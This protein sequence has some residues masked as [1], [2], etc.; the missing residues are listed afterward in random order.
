MAAALRDMDVEALIALLG[1]SADFYGDEQVTQLTHALQAASLAERDGAPPS[2]VAAALLHD[3]GHLLAKPR[4]GADDRHE[5]IGSGLL[6]RLFGAAVAEPVRLH[7]D[8]KR[9][10]CATEPGYFATL[11]EA[12]VRSLERQG[13]PFTADEADRFAQKP[14]AAAAI[15]L[16]RWDEQAKALNAA[17]PD[18]AYYAPLLRSLAG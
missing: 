17:T 16:R 6:E 12:S 14:F 2:L 5:R 4:D 7:V 1:E 13:G 9:F 18:I 8:A 3:V 15:R 11:S 10:L